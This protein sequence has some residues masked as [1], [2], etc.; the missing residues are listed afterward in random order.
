M[1]P[2]VFLNT[3]EDFLINMADGSVRVLHETA[4]YMKL[5]DEGVR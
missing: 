1:D 4:V 5:L 3:L 2:E